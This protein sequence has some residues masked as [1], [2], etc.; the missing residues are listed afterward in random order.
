MEIGRIY[1]ACTT[2]K[3]KFSQTKSTF[4]SVLPS[5]NDTHSF[6]KAHIWIIFL[7]AS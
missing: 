5:D 7:L 1:L 2:A 6:T 4:G 3:L